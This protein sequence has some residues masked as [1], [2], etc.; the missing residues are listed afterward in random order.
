MFQVCVLLTFVLCARLALAVY[1][2]PLANEWLL[3]DV[4]EPCPQP[5]ELALP[6]VGGTGYLQS[7]HVSP[8]RL[9]GSF[10]CR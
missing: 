3:L 10:V 6:I 9:W 5:H 8:Q 7:L 4:N 2:Q 1:V